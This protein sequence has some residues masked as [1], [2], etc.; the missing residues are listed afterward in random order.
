MKG[1]LE[2][3]RENYLE[4]RNLLQHNKTRIMFSKLFKGCPLKNSKENSKKE[5]FE[6]TNYLKNR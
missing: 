4:E 6:P 2:I 1:T 5:L 3:R